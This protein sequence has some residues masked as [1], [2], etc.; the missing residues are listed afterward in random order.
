VIRLV[1]LV[2]AVALVAC[3]LTKPPPPAPERRTN[4][5]LPIETLE[6]ANGLR[7]VAIRD[8]KAVEVQVTMRYQVGSVDDPSDHPGMAH[9]VEHLMYQQVLGARCAIPGWSDGSSTEP[10][11]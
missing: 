7:V 2:G 8:P 11:W 4:W 6:L 3:V 9:L 5:G 1:G 10:T